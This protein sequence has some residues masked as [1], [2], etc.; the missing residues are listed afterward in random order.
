MSARNGSTRSGSTIAALRT[1][2]NQKGDG[3]DGSNQLRN[4]RA[5]GRGV[6]RRTR[7]SEEAEAPNLWWSVRRGAARPRAARRQSTRWICRPPPFFLA[8][9]RRLTDTTGLPPTDRYRQSRARPHACCPSVRPSVY[10][11]ILLRTA[12]VAAA[13]CWAP[14]NGGAV[15]RRAEI[16]GGEE[17]DLNACAAGTGS[18]RVW[19]LPPLFLQR[20]TLLR[21]AAFLPAAPRWLG[22][23]GVGM[24]SRCDVTPQHPACIYGNAPSDTQL[25]VMFT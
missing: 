4:P 17:W 7:R 5:S 20:H 8:T 12:A 3:G 6:E 15:V 10:P 19:R 23:G 14:G 22:V 18:G 2:L 21:S 25:L 24:W 1:P 16:W 9:R 11:P 13:G